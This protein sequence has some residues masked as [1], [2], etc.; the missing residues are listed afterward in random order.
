[1]ASPS[2][3]MT[4]SALPGC[5]LAIILF[6]ASTMVQPTEAATRKNSTSRVSTS[7]S[8]GG[9]LVVCYY[10]NWSVYR[11]GR[12]KFTPSNVNPY[13]C[14][15]L[16]YA[17]G[18]LSSEDGL[19]PYDKYQDIEQGGYAKFNGLKSYNKALKTLLAVGGWNEGSARFSSL[20]A[21]PER[22]TKF[23]KGAVRFLR[24]HRF[25]GLDLD[26]E[27]PAFRDGGR[28]QDKENYAKLAEDLRAEFDKE[29][30]QTGRPRLLLTMA[31]PAGKEYIDR[32]FD[33]SR[34]SSQLDFLN[35]LSYDY[36][37]AFEPVVNH[38][39]P[40]YPLNRV[41]GGSEYDYDGELC[42]DFTVKHY[43]KAGVPSSQ[44]VLGI[45]TYGRSYTLLNPE[46]IDPGSPAD[47]PG[48]QGDATREKGYLSYY[49]ICKAVKSD[50]WTV[51]QPEPDAMGPYA[52]KGDQWVG[53]DDPDTIRKKA[54]YVHEMSLGGLMFW[55]V[56]NDDFRGDCHGK[57]Y[58]LVEAGKEELLRL[59]GPST[60]STSKSRVGGSTSGNRR[61]PTGGSGGRK[62]RPSTTSTTTSTTT[63]TT[64]S[65]GSLTTPEPPTTPDP[66]SDFVC[67]DEGFFPH[68]R[69]C[70]KYFWCLDSG[71]SSLGIVAHQFTCPSG[72]FFNKAADSCDYSR[73][74]LC[75][76]KLTESTSTTTKAP[77]T[78][79]GTTT[80]RRTTA[81]TTTTTTTTTE[82]P[83]YEEYDEE[84]E[85][86][87]GSL[88]EDPSALKELIG[89]IKKLG[90]L[91]ELEKHL[92][93]SNSGSK[94]T[95]ASPI[96]KGSSSLYERVLGS[97]GK[98][99]PPVLNA[100]RPPPPAP[101]SAPSVR[102]ALKYVSLRR[103]RP[104]KV[105][106]EEQ[107]EEFEEEEEEEEEEVPQRNVKTRRP[108]TGNTR[109]FSGERPK[110]VTI[111][112]PRPSTTPQSPL[113]EDEEE[114]ED[115]GVDTRE[116]E[117]EVGTPR[118]VTIRRP[119]PTRVTEPEI[120][121]PRY[122]VIDR[123]RFGGETARESPS[124]K[125]EIEEKATT[126]PSTTSTPIHSSSF[127]SIAASSSPSLLSSPEP[128]SPIYLSTTTAPSTVTRVITSVTEAATER[129]IIAVARV[130]Y[131]VLLGARNA[132]NR[133]TVSDGQDK[134]NDSVSTGGNLAKDEF[135][136]FESN[137]RPPPTNQSIQDSMSPKEEPPSE[138]TGEQPRENLTT[139]IPEIVSPTIPTTSSPIP[140][141]NVRFSPTRKSYTST[142]T[143][144]TTPKARTRT[145]PFI[146]RGFRRFNS[147]TEGVKTTTDHENKIGLT[148]TRSYP[149]VRGSQNQASQGG[150]R[151][152][153]GVT[154]TS[155][156]PT[157]AEPLD[158]VAEEDTPTTHRPRL[159]VLVVTT[160][161]SYSE[162]PPTSN[163]VNETEETTNAATTTS[164]T[165]R[166]I[167]TS[168]RPLFAPRG[169]TLALG[170]RRVTTARRKIVIPS[171]RIGD[172][173][174]E[175][176]TTT[177]L[178][179]A[180]LVGEERK[181]P[182]I[183]GTVRQKDNT[184]D[185]VVD[186][187]GY[188][189]VGDKRDGDLFEESEEVI[190]EVTSQ[191]P[192]SIRRPSTRRP[193][194]RPTSSIG[195]SRAAG[196]SLPRRTSTTRR[197][198]VQPAGDDDDYDYF[199]I[200]TGSTS[201][202]VRVRVDGT[203][204]CLDRGNFPHPLAFRSDDNI[205]PSCNRRFVSCAEVEGNILGWEYECPRHLTFDPIGGICNWAPEGLG[206]D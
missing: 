153:G 125:P 147:P 135:P 57:P 114:E 206:C 96:N 7:S 155:T 83:E 164:T 104:A 185:V 63:T 167:S 22:R 159:R 80:T 172:D 35:I 119:R 150:F 88:E 72:L 200:P 48:A 78:S 36:H 87:D 171:A 202:K 85:E 109:V 183:R 106:P 134:P 102:P 169:N 92:D 82:A 34:L 195:S 187:K 141:E 8:S 47:G 108:P 71:P 64:P 154:K 98:R 162:E 145:N 86:E 18:G 33:M 110:Y 20:A 59:A 168:R 29:S 131:S 118:Y 175:S 90:G 107:E 194:P 177:V 179:A 11:P 124:E 148:R 77:A 105:E 69:D 151:R 5:L 193:S 133:T 37:S 56:D 74:V 79:A 42:I 196:S 46:S 140:E 180:P 60:K 121:T 203:V 65:Y 17:F 75:K 49:E 143:E 68:P 198:A 156:A 51:E 204:Q 178:A 117:P 139:S 157:T 28:P 32:G 184:P 176:H 45:P 165:E 3:M 91:K 15:H 188:D 181:I 53:Y 158:L 40:L 174:S 19:R 173:N 163:P 100:R 94:G 4:P 89:L 73:N 127:A 70:K 54:R 76:K 10:T 112:R 136:S 31:V 81:R 1:M 122:Q 128:P 191:K 27:F 23:A 97:R 93:S 170:R 205:P 9:P 130:P 99:P 190:V 14:S 111:N 146:Q 113:E 126:F 39:S 16:I 84:E 6:A 44:L 55:S 161:V 152:D 197:P 116:P 142:T 101:T 166:A 25:D 62:R 137:E 138:A 61:R 115:T 186:G 67:K 182:A 52:Y 199:D 43:L 120:S 38:H 189:E 50:D 26:W 192:A 123:R 30:S 149:G 103:E 160:D 132:N 13:L 2:G 58:P 12:A 66:G 24:T 41:E 129:Q 21:D 201:E 144:A 95:T